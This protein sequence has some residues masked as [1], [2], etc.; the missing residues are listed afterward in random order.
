V[1]FFPLRGDGDPAEQLRWLLGRS[2][3][4]LP[5]PGTRSIEHLRENLAV[6]A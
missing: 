5:I 2:P 4:V 6:L 3:V 1:P